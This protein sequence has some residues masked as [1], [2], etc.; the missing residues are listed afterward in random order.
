MKLD[1]RKDV[2]VFY[3][4][5]DQDVARRKNI[6][7][8]FERLGITRHERIPGVKSRKKYLGA[9]LA[10]FHAAC[11][12]RGRLPALVLE[13]DAKETGWYTPIIDIPDE[14]DRVYLGHSLYG[15][16]GPG[17]SEL[18]KVAIYKYSSKCIRILNMCGTHA[19]LHVTE[20]YV[21]NSLKV[22]SK[23]C[24]DS[25]IK[26]DNCPADRY[27]ARNMGRHIVLATNDPLFLQDDVT[28]QATWISLTRR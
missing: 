8:M 20:S 22:I 10:A 16:V 9:N 26:S 15:P 21:E 3:I 24:R 28:E 23:A 25:A 14:T 13:D 6:E 19:V 5:L 27:L 7:N 4:N 1:L 17:H 11:Y 12:I 18:G 2:N